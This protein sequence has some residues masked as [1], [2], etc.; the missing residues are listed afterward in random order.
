MLDKGYPVDAALG[1]LVVET[2]RGLTFSPLAHQT[3]R[4][5]VIHCYGESNRG[6]G[7]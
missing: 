1:E 6:T 2:P 4:E 5:T 7:R 3:Y